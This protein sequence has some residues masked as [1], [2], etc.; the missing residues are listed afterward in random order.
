[1]ASPHLSLSLSRELWNGM[2]RAALP[3]AVADGDVNLLGA[4]RATVR[5]LGVKERVTGLLNDGRTPAPV[6]R[7]GERAVELW[8]GRKEDVLRT[9][10]RLVH[11]EGSWSLEI[12]D[13]GTEIVYGPQKLTA[14]AWVKGVAEGRITLIG[15]GIVLPFRIEQ[16][17][18]ATV[19]L[20]RIRYAR[21]RQAVLANVQD[22]ALHL[23]DGAVL[24]L[25]GR[26]A[27]VVLA[28]RLDAVEP[29]PILKREQIEGLVGPL[30]G[31]LK[32]LLEVADLFLAVDEERMT[33]EVRFGF[34]KASEAPQL[35]QDDA[36]W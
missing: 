25:L 14:E 12:D 13:L 8:R 21:E 2:L 9:V 32:I 36:A 23:G 31:P 17:L 34:A 29:L 6:T 30:G 28:Q 24:Q 27:E 18:G 33:L 16:R 22:V 10:D 15:E 19:A 3:Y 20:G 1:M 4:A 7:L 11:V 26:L 5:Q 35:G